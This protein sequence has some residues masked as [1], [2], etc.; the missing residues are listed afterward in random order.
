MVD[1]RGNKKHPLWLA[2]KRVIKENNIVKALEGK[3][4]DKN[5]KRKNRPH[6]S[7]N[8]DEFQNY[9]IFDYN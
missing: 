7:Y 2:K 6:Q 9:S 1:K 5:A 4:D 8:L 3:Y